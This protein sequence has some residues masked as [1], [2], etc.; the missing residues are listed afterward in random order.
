[1]TTLNLESAPLLVNYTVANLNHTAFRAVANQA[2][3]QEK[4]FMRRR[5]PTQHLPF[6]PGSLLSTQSYEEAAAT[7]NDKL[8]EL[9]TVQPQ[10][11]GGRA[12]IRF[13]LRDLP[14]IKLFGAYWGEDAVAV[15][16]TPLTSWHGILPLE[17]GIRDLRSGRQV[18]AKEMIIFT[19]G[20]EIDIVWEG[21]TRA[22]VASLED[23]LLR[24]HFETAYDMPMPDFSERI[25]CIGQKHP[26]LVSMANL[27]RLADAEFRQDGG[28]FGSP[29]ALHHLQSLFCENLLQMLPSDYHL[30]QRR[31]LPGPLKRAVDYIH[32][33]LE[34][35]WSMEELLRVSGAS[36]RTLE[37]AFRDNLQTSPMRYLQQCRLNLARER[38]RKARP[39]DIQLADLAHRLGFAQPSH[40]TTAYK[41]AF[42]ELPSETLARI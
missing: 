11:R 10:R 3:T 23:R 7:L 26:A 41:Q 22:I 35:P 37:K 8:R 36:R 20:H 15:S 18:K 40:F 12:D 31:V 13:T 17:G 29:I 32:Q 38:L 28:M 27:L 2:Q 25:L 4:T 39:G 34:Q 42:G 9:R 6:A 16:S 33:H 21:G 30:S 24:Q 14:N 1:M 5:P 19:P